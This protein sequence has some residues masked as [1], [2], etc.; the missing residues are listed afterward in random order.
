MMSK[1]A[2]SLKSILN[3]AVGLCLRGLRLKQALRPLFDGGPVVRK[4]DRVQF[5]MQFVG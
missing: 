1:N 2:A 4:I 3:A 5:Q